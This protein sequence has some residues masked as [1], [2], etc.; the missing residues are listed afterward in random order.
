MP[1]RRA[2]LVLGAG[3]L[4]MPLACLQGAPARGTG[5]GGAAGGRGGAAAGGSGDG[6][7]LR[8]VPPDLLNTNVAGQDE[9]LT[10][11]AATLVQAGQGLVLYAAA[12]NDSDTP[13]C[14]PGM[15]TEL[16]DKS[17][18]QLTSAGSVVQTDRFYRLSDGTIIACL[19]PG[20]IGMAIADFPDAIA[21]AEVGSLQHLFP[22]FI[23]P[24]IAPVTG[25]T[26]AD[27]AAAGDRYSGTLTNLLDV[28]VASPQVLIFP[29]NRAGRPLGVAT[30]SGPS[31][32]PAG[33]RWDFTTSSVASLGVDDYAFPAG[34]PAQ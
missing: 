19:D 23:V 13:L 31:D 29:V 10:L 24:D 30:A 22:T 20:Q 2:L 3:A 17:G 26:L 9:G 4:L 7:D 21:I 15:T 16:F 18:Q 25:L 1:A 5:A 28:A 33:G 14:Q 27:V 32:L 11:L 6:A 8:F 34:S 12:R